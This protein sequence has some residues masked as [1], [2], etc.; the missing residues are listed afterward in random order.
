MQPRYY[1][2]TDGVCV[3]ELADRIT[4]LVSGALY[5]GVQL[6]SEYAP[7]NAIGAALKANSFTPRRPQHYL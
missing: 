1:N 7:P 4:M 6:Y 5:E 2:T 3:A